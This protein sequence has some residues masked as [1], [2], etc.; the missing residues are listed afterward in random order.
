MSTDQPGQGPPD[1]PFGERR[2]DGGDRQPGGDG[3][4]FGDGPYGAPPRGRGGP[5]GP[6]GEGRGPYEQDPWGR[7][8]SGQPPGD[9]GQDDR[10]PYGHNPYSGRPRGSGPDPMAGMPPAAATGKRVLARIIDIVIVLLPAYLL[11]WGIA[12]V[13]NGSATLGRSAVG[14]VFAAGLGYLY[15]FYT[16]RSSGQTVGKKMM[17]IRT[18]ML[19]DGSV[20][21]QT[22]SA[23]RAGVLWVPVFFCSFVWFLIIGLT[24]IF[25]RPYRQGVQDRLAKTVVVEIA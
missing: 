19:S 20:P 5:Q 21:T 18:A 1:D 7:G 23:V 8:P 13:Q 14:G 25:D 11:D 9:Q 6:G 16:T 22:A 15:E 24:V 12:S 10:N 3:G 4:A 2:G 17:A